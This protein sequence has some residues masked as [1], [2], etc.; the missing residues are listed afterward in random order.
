MT[1]QGSLEISSL[2]LPNFYCSVFARCRDLSELGM[3]RHV[4][5]GT[6][7]P[8]HL[9]F[10][11]HFRYVQILNFDI[12]SLLPIAALAKLLLKA[13]HLLLKVVYFFLEIQN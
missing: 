3:E 13:D 12:S 1:L 7:V 6:F 2:D 11:R 9:K 8:L 4:G 10:S 5:Y